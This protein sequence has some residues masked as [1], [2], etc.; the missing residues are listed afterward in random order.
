MVKL[1]RMGWRQH[2]AYM[3]RKRNAY[4]VLVGNSKQINPLEDSH[5]DWRVSLKWTL[6]K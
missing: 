2:V 6:K 1:R 3:D 5:M 4:T